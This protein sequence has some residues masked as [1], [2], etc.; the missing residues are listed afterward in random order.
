MRADITRKP[1]AEYIPLW[2][3]LKAAALEGKSVHVACAPAM[4]QRVRR[5][6]KNTKWA[7]RMYQARYHGTLRFEETPDGWNITLT[8]APSRALRT[9]DM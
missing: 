9:T 2:D 6:L 1:A 3:A 8:Q 5:M 7:D 4:R